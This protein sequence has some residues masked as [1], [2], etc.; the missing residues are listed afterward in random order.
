MLKHIIGQSIF[1][2]VVILFL[3]FAGEY[4]IPEYSDS[5]DTST[6][7]NNPEMKWHNGQVG[8]TVR[9]GR[10]YHPSGAYD[11]FS[12]FDE[13]R[14]YSRHLTFVFN[15]FVMMQIFDF[16]NARKLHEE[17]KLYLFS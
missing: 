14:I 6:F 13:H 9:S 3:V 10:F 5:Y 7:K 12:V 17:V 8:G 4:W 2:L 16:F 15:T 1:Q 11:Y